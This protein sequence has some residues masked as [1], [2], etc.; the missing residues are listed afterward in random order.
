[1]HIDCI[2]IRYRGIYKVSHRNARNDMYPALHLIDI[3]LV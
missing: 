2:D 1:M 3:G